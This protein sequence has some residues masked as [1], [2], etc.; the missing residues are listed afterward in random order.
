MK[1]LHSVNGLGCMGMICQS[2][3]TNRLIKCD[4]EFCGGFKSKR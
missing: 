2:N 3:E 4:G 1:I